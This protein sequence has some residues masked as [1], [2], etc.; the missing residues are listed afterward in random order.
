M[1]TSLLEFNMSASAPVTSSAA[2]R[3]RTQP[4]PLAVG[5]NLK[6]R[7]VEDL[8]L[9][10]KYAS[11][12]L[13][14]ID[15]YAILSEGTNALFTFPGAFKQTFMPEIVKTLH[16]F[17]KAKVDVFCLAVESPDVMR[18][19]K[20]SLTPP[21]GPELHLFMLADR[22]GKLTFTLGLGQDLSDQG[23]DFCAVPAAVMF[24]EGRVLAIDIN[25]PIPETVLAR[26][27]AIV[28]DIK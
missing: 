18:A 22:G 14:P 12:D 9:Y 2:E 23:L 4:K 16:L 8:T 20:V 27:S 1:A 13:F 11:G 25:K 28:E 6:G 17:R 3:V 5:D 19:L 26:I 21:Q 10:N 7:K 15:P 24:Q